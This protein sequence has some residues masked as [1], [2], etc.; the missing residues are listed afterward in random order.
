MF[1]INFLQLNNVDVKN[2]NYMLLILDL[3][4]TSFF[5]LFVTF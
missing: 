3:I 2:S 5:S 1:N 4:I